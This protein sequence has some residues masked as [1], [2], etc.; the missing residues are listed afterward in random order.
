LSSVG[1]FDLT[2]A[3]TQ[4]RLLGLF[5]SLK[6][7]RVAYAIAILSLGLA[8]SAKTGS[9]YLIRFFVDDVLGKAGQSYLLPAVAI[10]FVGFALTQGAFSF[11]SG[12]LAARVSEGVVQRIRDYLYDHIQQLPFSYH[13]RTPTGE[14]I[15]RCTS[16][17]EAIRRLFAMQAVAVGR[18]LFMFIINFGA[19]LALS[20][21]LTFISVVAIPI[22]V[23][24]SIFFARWIASAYEK[25]QDQE[26]VLS[27]T[28]QENLSGI[29]VVKAFGRSEFE[30]QKF[31]QD[32]REKYRRGKKLIV[33]HAFFWPV[34]DLLCGF[35]IL[36]GYAVGAFM[37][38][39]G[40]I[41]LGTFIAYTGM[42][43]HI[44]W[45]MRMLG[46]VIVQA[47]TGIV[48][49]G[50]IA[51]IMREKR[52]PLFDGRFPSIEGRRAVGQT[53]ADRE[54]E[55]RGDI[56]FEG[57]SFQ[58]GEN[59][60]VL[61]ELSFV[62]KP[63][64]AVAL[65]G[66]PG[67]GKTS[68]VNLLPRFYDYNDGRLLLDGRELKEYSRH[69]LRRHIG[70]VE[71][72]PFLFSRTVR[73]NI[74]YGVDRKVDEAE[75]VR[76]AKFAAVHDVIT[77]FPKGYETIVGEKG[78][79]LSGGQ[80]QRIAIARTLL[81]DPRILILDDSTSSVDMETEMVIRQALEEL[82]QNRTTFVI[83]HRIQSLMKAD[84]ILV[85]DQGQ[86]V[87]RGTHAQLVEEEGFYRRIFD[88]QSR[89]GLEDSKE[90]GDVLF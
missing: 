25:Y 37:V 49:F 20:M 77:E 70:I 6:G 79:T 85:L 40:E 19:I 26:A 60:P 22:V 89:L 2:Y 43:I 51:E 3:V 67:S 50:R 12:R 14:L 8:A 76:A 44:I 59:V 62:C 90:L 32:N 72:E 71:Q 4:N 34:T 80:K 53:S 17:V 61:K 55:V 23:V 75:I 9:F 64:Q 52:E 24:L 36:I 87:Q 7:F 81:K 88:M 42:V 11:L 35:Q 33:T 63:G 68:L 86:I 31:E 56:R 73:E 83:A 46:R 48:S 41:T 10:G 74:T 78:V 66:P 15:Q 21:R 69:F 39:G 13:D 16:D 5:R 18:I 30:M 45:P 28:L 65:L 1:A 38:M 82:M 57:V 47:A 29:R 54:L 84:L 27:T 58:Y